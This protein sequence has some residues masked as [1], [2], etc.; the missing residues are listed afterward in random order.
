MTNEIQKHQRMKILIATDGSKHS[1]A[2]IESCRTII[3]EKTA[4]V[5]ILSVFE[6]PMVTVAA[7]PYAVAVQF[8]PMLEK[9]F[10]ELSAQAV[11]QAERQLREIFPELK[12]NLTTKVVCSGSPAQAIVEEAENWGANLIVVGSHG[13]GFWERMLL[14]SVSNAVVHHA[15]CSVLIV[16]NN[17]KNKKNGSSK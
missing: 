17:A 16:R 14:G 9:E 12:E 7:A 1:D 3:D 8:D 2:I 4:E 11:A 10:R 6:Q 5:E 13:Y 15:P